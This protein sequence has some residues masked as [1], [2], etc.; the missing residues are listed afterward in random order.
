[1]P[2]VMS[3]SMRTLMESILC[4]PEVGTDARM[5]V[6]EGHLEDLVQAPELALF[7]SSHLRLGDLQ[8]VLFI[9]GLIFLFLKQ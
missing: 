6:V 5:L 7:R 9:D 4:L 8:N 3:L 1:M 2:Y